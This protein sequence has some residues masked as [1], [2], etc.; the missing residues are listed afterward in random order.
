MA[1]SK[2]TNTEDAFAEID[3]LKAAEAAKADEPVVEIVEPETAVREP[4]VEHAPAKVDGVE[5]LK[6]QIEAEKKAR[7]EAE[8]RANQ[9]SQEVHK[10][11]K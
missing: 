2:N 11:E 9:A 8:Q 5:E 10:Y 4:E 7:I 3:K 6:R 1:K